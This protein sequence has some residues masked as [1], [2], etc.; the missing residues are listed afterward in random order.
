MFVHSS[1]QCWL[2]GSTSTRS[3]YHPAFF[4]WSS[5]LCNMCSYQCG[6]G[7]WLPSA[8]RSPSWFCFWRIRSVLVYDL[9]LLLAE[10]AI[11]PCGH[12][13]FPFATGMPRMVA[14][15]ESFLF[16]W[17]NLGMC[18]LCSGGA[19]WI[20]PGDIAIPVGSHPLVWSSLSHRSASS[21]LSCRHSSTKYFSCSIRS[22]SILSKIANM[23]DGFS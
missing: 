14:R 15:L 16:C 12:Y 18:G 2:H 13:S 4:S 8:G 10:C 5:S 9:A 6:F 23:V 17:R 3:R 7:A 11:V 22:L 21:S 1:L 19:V 20:G